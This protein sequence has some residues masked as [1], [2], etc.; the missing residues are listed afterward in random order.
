M[1]RVTKPFDMVLF[2]YATLSHN[3]AVTSAI[4][5]SSRGEMFRDQVVC[6]DLA[7]LMVQLRAPT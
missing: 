5:R 4:Q 7:T 1:P 2:I 6:S 3:A